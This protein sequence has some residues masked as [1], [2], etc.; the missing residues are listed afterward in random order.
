[1]DEFEKVVREGRETLAI[2]FKAP[3]SW[4][5]DDTKAKVIK[6]ALAMA[7]KRDGGLVVFGMGSHPTERGRHVPTGMTPEQVDSFNP[8]HVVAKV[9]AHSDPSIDLSI[10]LRTCDGCALIAIA[11]REFANYPVICREAFYVGGKAVIL[12]G[13]MY[14]RSRRMPESSEVHRH[15]DLR[16]I[17]DLATE[18]AVAR[19]A[20]LREIERRE[21]ADQRKGEEARSEFRRQAEDLLS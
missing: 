2:E 3:M 19:H 16:E 6:A 18:K 17:I 11:V 13:R 20:R 15:E 10:T 5:D 4:A 21:A 9:N 14:C 1:M 8:D 7:N 12:R